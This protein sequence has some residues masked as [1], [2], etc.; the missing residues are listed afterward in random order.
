MEGI[1]IIPLRSFSYGGEQKNGAEPGEMRGS[2]ENCKLELTLCFRM[3]VN[4]SSDKKKLND[5]GEKG[6]ICLSH[7]LERRN[8]T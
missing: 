8:G 5:P 6:K 1:R 4:S 2:R 3:T 7:V